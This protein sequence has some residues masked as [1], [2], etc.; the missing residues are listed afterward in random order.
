MWEMP[1]T[2]AKG[3]KKFD[4]VAL[5]CMLSAKMELLGMARGVPRGPS[6]IDFNT[7]QLLKVLFKF[8]RKLENQLFFKNSHPCQE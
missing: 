2:Q 1:A 6:G 7:P 5:R 3:K 8:P 4:L